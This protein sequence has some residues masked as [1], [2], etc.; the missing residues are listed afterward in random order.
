MYSAIM[1]IFVTV[2]TTVC[3]GQ[4]TEGIMAMV[5]GAVKQGK[6]TRIKCLLGCHCQSRLT[7]SVK[8]PKLLRRRV[9]HEHL[10]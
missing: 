6:D 5:D 3:F 2:I 1:N 10:N 7:K 4:L 8:P 9:N